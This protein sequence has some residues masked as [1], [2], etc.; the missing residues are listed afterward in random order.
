YNI[1]Q[2]S[3][4]S[5]ERIFLILDSS[6][7][8]QQPVADIG[9]HTEFRSKPVSTAL[10]KISEISMEKVSFEYVKD[11]P[12]LKN[13][14]FSIKAG[15]TL[16]VVGPTGSGKTSMINLIIRFYDPT[17]GRV[18]LNGVDIKEKNINA[19]RVKMALVMQ[20][21]FLFSDTIRENITLGARNL[22][23]STFQQILQDSNCKTLVD[24]LPEGVH[25]VLSEGGTS[26]SSGERQ[27]I[28]IARAFARNPDLIILDEATSYIDS[29]TEVKI[30]E[31]LTKLMSNRTSIIVAHRLS[32]VREAD[33]IIVLNRGQ[34]IESGNHSELMKIKGFYYRLNQL[35]G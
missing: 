1:L 21:P 10:D 8:I 2:N 16:A 25:T 33:K 14:S 22:S 28:S 7:T 13:V 6:E 27:F 26:I 23:E 34:I 12:V 32:T 5:A 17:S 30:Q 20:D 35:Q 15:E 24:K 18:L 3:M 11:E 31:A 9:F 19:L 29:E 4:A